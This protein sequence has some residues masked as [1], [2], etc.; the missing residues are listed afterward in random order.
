MAAY[1]AKVAGQ[2]PWA[3]HTIDNSSQGA[4]GVRLADV[5]GDGPEDITSGWEEGGKIRVYLNPGAARAAQPWPVVNVG[6]AARRHG[7]R[8]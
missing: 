1:S 5:N 4:D 7:W 3:R 8:R 6:A 2:Q